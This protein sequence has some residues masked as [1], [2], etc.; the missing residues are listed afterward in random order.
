MIGTVSNEPSAG[1]WQCDLATAQS[2]C[3]IPYAAYPSPYA[4]RKG[5]GSG[6]VRLPSGGDL[7]YDIFQPAHLDRRISHKYPLIIGD[8]YFGNVVNGAHGRLWI[9]AVAAC[10]AYVVIVNRRDWANGIEQWGEDVMAVY[11]H[12]LDNPNIDKNRVYLF[13]VSAETQY[14]SDF[15]VQSPGLWKGVILLNPTGLPDF[16]KSPPF[17]QRPQFLLSVGGLEG[18]DARLKQYQEEALKYGAT[19][20]FIIHPGE[21]HHLIG[22]AA[23]LQRTTALVHF[24]FEE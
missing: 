21:G 8:T 17:Q 5:H 16:S 15:V 9:P 20:D 10:D 12:L 2:R 14:L 24:I 11:R 22:N 23:Q 6:S 3:V 18:E 19:V 13:G 7:N 1:L 4:T